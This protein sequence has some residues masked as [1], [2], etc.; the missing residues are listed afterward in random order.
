MLNKQHLLR[1]AIMNFHKRWRVRGKLDSLKIAR[2][3]DDL[4]EE[5]IFPTQ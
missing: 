4:F 5:T 1:F 2:L 3:C